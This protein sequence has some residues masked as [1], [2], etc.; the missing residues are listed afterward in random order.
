MLRKLW[1][2]FV[3]EYYFA[4]FDVN[5]FEHPNTL[6]C[7]LSPFDLVKFWHIMNLFFNNNWPLEPHLESKTK[8]PTQTWCSSKHHFL[9]ILMAKSTLK[10]HIFDKKTTFL[11]FHPRV[12]RQLRPAS[13][14]TANNFEG[15]EARRSSQMR[16]LIILGL[17]KNAHFWTKIC[18]F[19]AVW[20]I[21][22]PAKLPL[23]VIFW[24]WDLYHSMSKS[25][26][27]KG[28]IHLS[29]FNIR[30][31]RIFFSTGHLAHISA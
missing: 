7:S 23:K 10:K 4:L 26:N 28:K 31:L 19:L 13:G 17:L 30:I 14:T 12:G 1:F 11:P 15:L 25:T 16:N 8:T 27:L 6:L 2:N 9:G 18:H 3:F 20:K 21:Q 24:A 5:G 22:P 29:T